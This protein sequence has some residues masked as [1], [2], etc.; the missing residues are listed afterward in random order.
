MFKTIVSTVIALTVVSGSVLAAAPA[1]AATVKVCGVALADS[2]NITTMSKAAQVADIAK[3]VK[4]LKGACQFRAV[5]AFNKSGPS[6]YAAPKKGIK[7]D[8]LQSFYNKL[9]VVEIKA[10]ILKAGGTLF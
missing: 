5:A 10:A 8:Q 2:G 4:T 9:S 3:T 6:L 1:Q 7:G